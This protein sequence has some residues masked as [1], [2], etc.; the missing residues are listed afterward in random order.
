LL[1]ASYLSAS[2]LWST[3]P[4]PSR[5]LTLLMMVSL[6]FLVHQMVDTPDKL[7]AILLSYL[8][9]SLLLAI[10]ATEWFM[11]HPE[12]RIRLSSITSVGEGLN[13]GSLPAFISLG[14]L[15]CLIRAVFSK[16]PRVIFWVL[17]FLALILVAFGSGTRTGLIA[18]GA[19]FL[20]LLF[21]ISTKRERR[22]L[23]VIPLVFATLL[24]ALYLLPESIL[25]RYQLINLKQGTLG[26]FEVFKIGVV[27]FMEH[28]VLGVGLGNSALLSSS[29]YIIA[30]K[31][32]GITINYYLNPWRP[33]SPYYPLFIRDVH[34]IYLEAAAEGGIIAFVLL[35]WLLYSLIKSY[36]T[37]FKVLSPGSDIWQMGIVIGA[38]LVYVLVTGFSEPIITKKFLWLSLALVLSLR[39][40]AGNMKAPNSET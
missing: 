9:G 38:F 31:K 13:P 1:F 10:V 24:A 32:Y 37:S 33:P 36:F 11:A 34:N 28:P 19:S 5:A 30:L 6:L 17:L 14:F 22:R 39:R 20:F 26:R 2:V 29:Y 18:L 40:V 35:M 15:Y 21:S 4:D 7:K 27:E 8:L 25:T 16:G 3:Y 12:E 23:L